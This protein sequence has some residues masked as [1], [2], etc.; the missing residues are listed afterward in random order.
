MGGG[1]E[2]REEREEKKSQRRV[3]LVRVFERLGR[4]LSI[5]TWYTWLNLCRMS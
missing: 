1:K 2:K 5:D 3:Q 4:I